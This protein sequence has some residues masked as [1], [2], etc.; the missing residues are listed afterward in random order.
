V[1]RAIERKLLPI[2]LVVFAKDDKVDEVTKQAYGV[3]QAYGTEASGTAQKLRAVRPDMDGRYVNRVRL[4][5]AK[6]WLDG[7]PVLAWMSKPFAVPPPGRDK[8]FHGY[9]QITDEVLFKAFDEHWT[10]PFQINMH[11]NGDEAV[12]QA[13]R[14]IEAAVARHGMR[15]HRPVF[16]H[17][18]YVRPDQIAR[19]KA[20]GAIPSFLTI[21]LFNQ[22][23]DL[24]PIFGAERMA[25]TNATASMQRAGI[26]FTL[27]H[28]APVTPPEILPLVWAATQRTTQHREEQVGNVEVARVACS[29]GLAVGTRGRLR[30]GRATSELRRERL[31]LRALGRQ[32]GGEGEHRD[33]ELEAVLSVRCPLGRG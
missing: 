26:P 21:S 15:D 10:T 3:G 5:G 23:D 9:S 16:V 1:L 25:T 18:A 12:E 11:L 27:S 17:C 7:N 6:F 31:C 30:E 19:M 2:D 8:D 4:G 29:G 14:A 32:L 13:L 24:A 28:D 22:G 20:L 33:A